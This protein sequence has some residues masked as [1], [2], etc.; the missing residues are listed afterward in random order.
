MLREHIWHPFRR[1]DS[2]NQLKEG[3]QKQCFGDSE[4]ERRHHVAG[5]MRAQV[6]S[7]ISNRQSDKPV[8]PAAATVKQ[9]KIRRGNCVVYSVP[10]WKRWSRAGPVGR[11]RKP[12]GRFLEQ[13]Q[14]FRTR[15]LQLHHPHGL[16]LFRP[17]TGH[18]RF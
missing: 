18:S 14:E 1:R 7:R 11:I 6:N 15:F 17:V 13:R 3:E 5:P 8:Q 12:N 16:H 9:S 4:K 10:R 2:P